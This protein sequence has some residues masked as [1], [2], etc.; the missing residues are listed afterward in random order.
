MFFQRPNHRSATAWREDRMFSLPLSRTKDISKRLV[1]I[2]LLVS[3]PKKL[4]LELS[5]WRAQSWT[6]LWVERQLVFARL[7]GLEG[8][9]RRVVR[10]YAG[11]CNLR[12]GK[13]SWFSKR[14]VKFR[15]TAKRDSR[16][17]A[18]TYYISKFQMWPT[19]SGCKFW[20]SLLI[21]M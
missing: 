8:G 3:T 12:K 10:C 19:K 14:L 9:I 21:K 11:P 15:I 7:V 13:C 2:V 4:R 5:N 1:R 6:G 18:N 20:R 17:Q 16:A